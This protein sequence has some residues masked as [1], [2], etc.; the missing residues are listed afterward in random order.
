MPFELGLA[1]AAGNPNTRKKS[2]FV[3]ETEHRRLS[4]SLS[5]L[6]GTDPY[7]HEGKP[8]GVMR[9]LGNL[10][11]RRSQPD[12][13]SVPEMMKTYRAVSRLVKQVQTQTGARTLFEA[14]AFRLLCTAASKA[15]NRL[16]AN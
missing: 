13:Y 11:G 12:R 9:E 2:W 8:E 7:I 16:Q 10:F 5:D 3:F 4:K 14:R 15:T 1:V 6:N